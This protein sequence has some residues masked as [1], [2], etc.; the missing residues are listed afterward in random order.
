MQARHIGVI[1]TTCPRCGTIGIYRGK[2]LLKKISLAATKTRH[3]VQVTAWAGGSATSAA[4][5]IKVLSATGH[6]VQIDGLA[7]TRL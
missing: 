3:G 5:R 7:V 2:T 1:V 4:I 6:L